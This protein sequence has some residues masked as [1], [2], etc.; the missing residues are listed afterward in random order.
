MTARATSPI[1]VERS[2]KREDTTPKQKLRNGERGIDPHATIHEARSRGTDTGT[3]KG[4][5]SVSPDKPLTEKQKL[6]VKF[7]AEGDS[8]PAASARAGY[9]DGAQMAYRMVYM[10]NVLKLKAQYE[11]KYEAESQMSRKKVMDGL[12]E[13]I[14]M[15]KLMA[16]PATM[17]SGWTA[18]AKMCGY[19][20]PVEHKVKVDVTGNVTMQTLTAM[21]DAELLEMIEKGHQNAS[22]Q[23]LTDQSDGRGAL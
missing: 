13:A 3:I 1:S 16:E 17:I 4:A 23:L 7:W 10:P 15:A 20:A 18:V 12:L 21:T 2:R 5:M 22:P 8:I 19:M 14:D 9:A 6:F 11:A